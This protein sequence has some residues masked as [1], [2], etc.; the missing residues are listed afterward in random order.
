VVIFDL[1]VNDDPANPAALAADLQA[2]A[3]AVGDRC[4]V[5]A[6]LSRPPL[7]GV[8]ID[9]LNEA[10]VAFATARPDTGLVDWRAAAQSHPD[11]IQSDGVH[12]TP[13]GYALRGHLVANAVRSCL[14]P[15]VAPPPSAPG[16]SGGERL[17]R[18]RAETAAIILGLTVRRIERPLS[19]LGSSPAALVLLAFL[20][21]VG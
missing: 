5:L 9:G 16:L 13:A 15:P 3:D 19:D 7:H 12:A 17:A 14:A 6:T 4:L 1:G 8:T 10:L 18:V 11:L 21:A 20:A 2:V